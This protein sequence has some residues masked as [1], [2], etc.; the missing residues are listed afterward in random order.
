[1]LENKSL[2]EIYNFNHFEYDTLTLKNEYI[3][4]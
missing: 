4:I 3:R 2:S 1:M